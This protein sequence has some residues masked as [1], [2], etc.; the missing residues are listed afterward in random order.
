MDARTFKDL[1]PQPA[2]EAG[3]LAPAALAEPKA[4]HRPDFAAAMRRVE[5]EVYDAI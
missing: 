5:A 2:T 3:D 4:Y 1:A